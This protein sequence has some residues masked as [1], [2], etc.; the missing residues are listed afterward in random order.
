VINAPRDAGE[1]RSCIVG[2]KNRG[3]SESM[4]PPLENW[5]NEQYEGR[6]SSVSGDV[7]AGTAK[8]CRCSG[9]CLSLQV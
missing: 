6:S 1:R 3:G 4:S 7:G 9:I 8:Y 5:F 2:T